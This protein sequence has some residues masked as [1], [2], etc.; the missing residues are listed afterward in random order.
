MGW[1][2]GIVTFTP[3]EHI[4]ITDNTVSYNLP[5]ADVIQQTQILG[6]L[7]GA[8]AISGRTFR[9]MHPY[10]DDPEAE[11]RMVQD[12]D[13]DEALRQSVL[14]KL[15]SGELPLIVSAII[16][17]HLSEGKDIFDAVTLADEEMRRRQAT[18]AP[19]A[20]EGMVA[21]PEAMPGL[22]APPQEMAAMQAPAPAPQAG[23]APD[24]QAQVAQLLQAMAGAR[25]AQG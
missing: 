25:N 5:G 13:F 14:Q 23:P 12:E 2:Q 9:A 1:R 19:P 22:S 18:E 7:R 21:P 17:K 8:K 20:P 16:K 4:E 24:R 10:I 3:Q 15:M 6:S 11:E